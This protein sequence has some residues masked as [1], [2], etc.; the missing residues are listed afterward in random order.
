MSYA[1]VLAL[2]QIQQERSANIIMQKQLA[3]ELCFV[4]KF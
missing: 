4:Q 1:T 2:H 3:K